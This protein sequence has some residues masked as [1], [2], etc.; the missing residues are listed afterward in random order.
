MLVILET[1]AANLG[2]C[3]TPMGNPQNLFL[4]SFYSIPVVDFFK[5]TL[6]I[7]IPSFI[8][9]FVS[10]ILITAGEKNK[11]FFF[12]KNDF[13][14]HPVRRVRTS[15]YSV[16]MLVILLSILFLIVILLIFLFYLQIRRWDNKKKRKKELAQM[17]QKDIAFFE[18]L[19]QMDL[20]KRKDSYD[21]SSHLDK[22]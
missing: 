11:P 4:Y 1:V 13:S 18:T 19:A 15:V 16:V 22:H 21:S 12:S 9:L 10:V 3:V 14:F 8:L 17:R 7:A 5:T 6:V 2:S 20:K